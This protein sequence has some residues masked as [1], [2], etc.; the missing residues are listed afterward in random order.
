MR[1]V[2]GCG[3]IGLCWDWIHHLLPSF[4]PFLCHLKSHTVIHAQVQESNAL[5]TAIPNT[6]IPSA[7]EESNQR[8]LI[9]YGVSVLR[10]TLRC[11]SASFH[12][13]P[14]K[15]ILPAATFTK[16]SL[17]VPIV[18]MV[19][20]IIASIGLGL[21]SVAT[22]AVAQGPAVRFA[23]VRFESEFPYRVSFFAS[24]DTDIDIDDVRV[25]FVTGPLSTEQ[26]AYMDLAARDDGMIEGK[27]EWRVN[28][29]ARYI[30]PGAVVKFH[31]QLFDKEGNE[32]LSE[33]YEGLV[34]DSRY[35]WD[36]VSAGPITVYYHGPV[37]SRARRL[38]DAA[39]ESLTIMAPI[40]GAEIETPII[41]TLY[42]NN[43]E[44]IGAVQA[45]SATI[46]R[47]LITEG[48]A[49]HQESVVLVLSGNRDIGTLTHELTHILV[50]RAAGGTS[51]LVPIWLNEGLAEYGNLDQGL[52]YDYFLEWAI[53]T[54]RLTPFSRLRTFPGDPDLIIV[55]YGQSRSIVDHLIS[56]Y[57]GE[58]IAETLAKIAAGVNADIAIR[59][60]YG[61]SVQ[62]L[63]NEWR[64]TVGADIYTQPTPTPSPDASAAPTP[65]LKL[66]T[67]T[68]IKGGVTVGESVTSTP[69]PAKVS[70]PTPAVATEPQPTI[71]ASATPTAISEPEREA[72]SSPST[73][74]SEPDASIAEA[75]DDA[76][77]ES[78]APESSSGGLCNSSL[79]GNTPLDASAPL[80]LILLG[81]FATALRY[82]RP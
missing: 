25:R 81:I 42:N 32:H 45:R 62:Q 82:R 24:F 28:T 38:A 5:Y 74:S 27:L 64:A 4:S 67:L 68:P 56:N 46:S 76:T 48:Q 17:F 1:F 44:M 13:M 63:D 36:S 72:P 22:T 15:S 34:T 71:T 31:F 10:N 47:E 51:A 49:F 9:E 65:A 54:N 50:G 7:G 37:E 29:S 73:P 55:S 60:I 78:Q 6:A 11:I 12:S 75:V 19:L 26:Y 58:K 33:V 20:G 43:A 30:P 70:T 8:A 18:L 59:E 61:K 66:L 39:M 21:L 23:D 14:R 41:V 40:T 69:E 3:S 80:A 79:D 77:D 35:E 52:S 57:G 16:A 2:P 53:D